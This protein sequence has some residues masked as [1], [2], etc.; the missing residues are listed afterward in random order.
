MKD[1]DVI[2]VLPLAL[3]C[4]TKSLTEVPLT[5]PIELRGKELTIEE[6]RQYASKPVTYIVRQL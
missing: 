5:L 4:Y 1:K 6:I 2:G 3:A